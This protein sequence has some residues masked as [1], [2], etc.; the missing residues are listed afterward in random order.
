LGLSVEQNVYGFRDG[1]F[2]IID[3][4]IT[5]D[6]QAE[7]LKDYYIGFWGDIDAPDGDGRDSPD[8]D[9]FG[10]TANGK[11]V[12][13]YDGE[14]KENIPLLGAMVL[15]I[16]APTISWW[17][18]D[19]DPKDDKQQ[20]R[21][22]LGDGE[23][24]SPDSPGDYRFLLSYGPISLT[25]GETIHFLVALAQTNDLNVLENNFAAAQEF[26]ERKLEMKFLQRTMEASSVEESIP[27]TYQLYPN[28]PN[29]FNPTTDIRF[30]LPEAAHVQLRIYDLLGRTVRN[31][32]EAEYT[33]GRHHL[34]WDGRDDHDRS[35]PSAIYLYELKAGSFQAQRKLLL[36]K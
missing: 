36:L 28:F 27:T 35:L 5:V 14:I 1:K 15:S 6:Q 17:K 24:I 25:T 20:Y 2:A 26:Y 30:D 10:L 21:Y 9:K 22:L 34:V 29:P 32:I 16:D 7:A 19:K 4:A 3:F 11:A 12:F 31:L 18:A 23:K 8:N 13:I 33:P